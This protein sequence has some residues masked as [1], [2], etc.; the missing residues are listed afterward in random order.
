MFAFHALVLI[1]C[2]RA[3]S[4]AVAAGVWPLALTLYAIAG[5]ALAA[6]FREISRAELAE[7][8][9]TSPRWV[10]WLRARREARRQ[11]PQHCCEQ[12]WPSLGETHSGQC[13]RGLAR[14]S[15]YLAEPAD[16]D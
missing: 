10:R 12:W 16:D 15:D 13:P 2:T 8:E 9:H 7:A 3:G 14:H 6:M 1:G 4:I 5:I 11:G